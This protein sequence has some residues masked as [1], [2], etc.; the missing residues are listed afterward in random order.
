MAAFLAWTAPPYGT[1]RATMPGVVEKLRQRI[2][3]DAPHRRTP[4]ITAQLGFGLLSLLTFAQ[5]A[6]VLTAAE[7]AQQ[8]EALWAALVRTAA[9]QSEHLAAQEPARRFLDL[10]GEA[11]AA[12]RAH[13]ASRNGGPPEPPVA[14]GWREAPPSGGFSSQREWRPQGPR[15]G[16]TE[17]V[18]VYLLPDEAYQ[19]ARRLSS[20]GDG[21]TIGVKTLTRRLHERGF[22][23]SRPA[24]GHRLLTRCIAEG[25]RHYV[26]HFHIRALSVV[27][28]SQTSP[29]SQPAAEETDWVE[30]TV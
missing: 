29:T 27:G 12:G 11:L 7:R 6:G 1:V 2:G 15:L 19:C 10:V 23:A 8:W 25:R 9:Q 16:W 20:D 28:T 17:G 4:V 22:L 14:W 3:E 26:M 30:M 21:L 24:A 5:V 18:D 13:V